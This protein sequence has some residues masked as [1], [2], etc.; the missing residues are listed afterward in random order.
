[1]KN[2]LIITS[3][4]IAIIGV[5]TSVIMNDLLFAISF[6]WILI[7]NIKNLP[8]HPDQTQKKCDKKNLSNPDQDEEE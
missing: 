3:I 2:F 8:L 5:T 1:M 4:F 6:L 7:E